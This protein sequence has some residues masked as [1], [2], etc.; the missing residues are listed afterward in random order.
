MDLVAYQILGHWIVIGNR[1]IFG[2]WTVIG[3]RSI[4]GHWIVID[5]RTTHAS[6]TP[7]DT[8]VTYYTFVYVYIIIS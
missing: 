7:P 3:N 1:T 4:I 6:G 8:I 5:K 2:H